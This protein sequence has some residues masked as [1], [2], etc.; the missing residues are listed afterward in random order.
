MLDLATPSLACD[1]LR[2]IHQ[3]TE[4]QNAIELDRHPSTSQKEK[5]KKE[6]T[7]SFANGSSSNT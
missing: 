7:F 4:Q 1:L 6:A 3:T 2:S 5:E